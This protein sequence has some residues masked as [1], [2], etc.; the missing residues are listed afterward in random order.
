MQGLIRGGLAFWGDTA[1]EKYGHFKKSYPE[2]ELL[3]NPKDKQLYFRKTGEGPFQ[4]IDPDMFS[5]PGALRDFPLDLLEFGA[6]EGLPILGEAAAFGLLRRPPVTTAAKVKTF[7]SQILS[8]ATTRPPALGTQASWLENTGRAAGGAYVGETA[9]QLAQT[10]GGTQNESLS[11][12]AGR[13]GEMAAYSAGGEL[14]V[15]PLIKVGNSTS[16]I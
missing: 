6:Q 9:R 14:V 5:D 15:K 11:A 7:L 10:L 16:S 3:R 13:A 2:G 12:Q 1:A 8:R 4:K